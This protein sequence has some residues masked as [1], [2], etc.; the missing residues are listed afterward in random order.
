M[1]DARLKQLLARRLGIA[2]GA[3]RLDEV[4]RGTLRERYVRCG[5]AGCH[6]REGPGHGPVS[7]LSVT[8]GR[9]DTT[10]FTIA[11]EDLETARQ[12]VANYERL[13]RALEGVSA[14]NRELLQ[15]RLLPRPGV[16]AQAAPATRRR[17][18]R[19]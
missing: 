16:P 7:Y 10:Q 11:P 17:R 18:R 4:L 12:L 6:C 8:L 13:R 9:G 3:P 14:V 19:R 2:R 15:K 5:K 1:S